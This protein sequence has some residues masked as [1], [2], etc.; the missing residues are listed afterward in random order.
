MTILASAKKDLKRLGATAKAA[1]TLSALHT[2]AVRARKASY[3]PYSKFAVGAALSLSGKKSLIFG[4]CNVENSSYG[5][6]VCA[7]RVAI[8]KAL[9][10]HPKSKVEFL[11]VVTDTSPAAPPCGICRQVLQEFSTKG[12]LLGQASL[13]G[14]ESVVSI[15]E[16]LPGPFD[17][18]PLRQV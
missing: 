15:Q 6:T 5:A 9:S 13:K 16:L 17:G 3:S 7:E 2:E 11:V 1:E 10:E 14:I 8:L 18:A 12:T 4:G